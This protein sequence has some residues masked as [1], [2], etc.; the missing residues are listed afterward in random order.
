[1]G[2]LRRGKPEERNTYELIKRLEKKPIDPTTGTPGG[3]KKAHA[4]VPIARSMRFW[5]RLDQELVG[6]L[7][8]SG[9]YHDPRAID[10]LL[11]QWGW[12]DI[13]DLADAR[14]LMRCLGTGRAEAFSDDEPEREPT[15][16]E[17]Q[18]ERQAKADRFR[19]FCQGRRQ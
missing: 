3:L 1:V 6:A 4:P 10:Y 12:D 7:D 16:A 11:G 15:L 18:R 19:G 14:Y 13:E 9:C 17:L 8:Q 2:R 5:L